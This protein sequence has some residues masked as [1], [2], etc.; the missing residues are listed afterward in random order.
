M[1]VGI[2][3][4]RKKRFVRG[5][6]RIRWGALSKDNAQELEGCLMNMGA[7]KNGG[8]ASAMWTMMAKYIREASRKALGIL[9]GYSGGHRGGWWW[10]DVVQGKLEAK[11]AAYIKLLESTDKDQRRANREGYKEAWKEAKLAVTKAKTAVFGR[12]YEELGGK[13]GDKKLFRLAKAREKKARDLDQVRCI[14]DKDD[15]V[16]MEEAQIRQR[17][18]SY[19][20]KLLNERGEWK[21]RVRAFGELRESPRL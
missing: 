15:R 18:Q 5:Q 19:F 16:L 11:R 20:H 12:L 4:K 10:N 7:W 6:S 3:L 14:K 17:W 9:K 13:G 8:D 21:H 1:D 2:L